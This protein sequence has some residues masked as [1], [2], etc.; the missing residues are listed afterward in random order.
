MRRRI[1]A[2]VTAIVIA[3]LAIFFLAPVNSTVVAPCIQ[4]S[5]NACEA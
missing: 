2:G 4:I 5:K 1:I 3:A